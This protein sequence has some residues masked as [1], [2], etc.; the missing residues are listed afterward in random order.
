MSGESKRLR[1]MLLV[2]STALLLSLDFA[3]PQSSGCDTFCQGFRK[4]LAERASNFSSLAIERAEHGGWTAIAVLPGSTDCS[5]LLAED[6]EPVSYSCFLGGPNLSRDDAIKRN[7]EI[8]SR[9]Q[10]SLPPGLTTDT[11]VNGALFNVKTEREGE[12]VASVTRDLRRGVITLVVIGQRT[13]P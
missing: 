9:I 12:R 6:A 11:I 4:L 8:V 10:S 3:S 5:L 2:G 7:D 1:V 13:N